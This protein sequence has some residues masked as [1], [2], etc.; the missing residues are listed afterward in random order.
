VPDLFGEYDI[1]RYN[2]LS[3]CYA[4]C[5]KSDDG[6]RSFVDRVVHGRR[7]VV[8]SIKNLLQFRQRLRLYF[9]QSMNDGVQFLAADRIYGEV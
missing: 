2:L 8:V 6:R 3:Q 4:V 1:V 9:K 5:S 7:S